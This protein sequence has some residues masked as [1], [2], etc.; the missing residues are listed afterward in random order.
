MRE[1]FQSPWEGASV[2]QCGSQWLGRDDGDGIIGMGA[3]EMGESAVNE[4]DAVKCNR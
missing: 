4:P 1:Y 3:R 2:A